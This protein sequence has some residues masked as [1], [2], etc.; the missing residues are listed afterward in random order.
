M[1]ILIKLIVGYSFRGLYVSLLI[2]KM[3]RSY[4]LL[5]LFLVLS[6]TFITVFIVYLSKLALVVDYASSEGSGCLSE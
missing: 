1:F 5:I 2:S 4:V 3:L 6:F